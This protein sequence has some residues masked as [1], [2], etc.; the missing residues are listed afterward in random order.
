MLTF[1]NPESPHKKSYFLD[2]Q[3]KWRNHMERKR[4]PAYGSIFVKTIDEF[5]PVTV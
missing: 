1:G 3:S 4:T 5:S 2:R